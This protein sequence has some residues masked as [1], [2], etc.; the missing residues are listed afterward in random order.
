VL[1][2]SER[3]WGRPQA[4]RYQDTIFATLD[5]LRDSPQIGKP[6]PD[7]AETCRSHPVERHVIYYVVE[8]DE[9]RVLRILHERQST[10]GQFDDPS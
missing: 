9:L 3:E 7:I 2:Y 8:G 6:R 4:D 1:A 5:T 10:R